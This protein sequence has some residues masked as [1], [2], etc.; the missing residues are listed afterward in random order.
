MQGHDMA[1]VPVR[2][3]YGLTVRRLDHQPRQLPFR[4]AGGGKPV[5]FISGGAA[6]FLFFRL[7]QRDHAMHLPDLGQTAQPQHVPQ[8][9]AVGDDALRLI[10]RAA[11]T[12]L[13][14]N[15]AALRLRSPRTG[16]QGHLKSAAH[17]GNAGKTKRQQPQIHIVSSSVHIPRTHLSHVPRGTSSTIW[18]E[19]ASPSVS[20]VPAPA[21]PP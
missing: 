9:R 8:R 16:R 14:R 20:G 11:R 2:H 4:S 7:K 17:P 3:K 6:K 21:V 15:I 10:I 19:K 13:Q 12:G 18:E 5:G 1:A